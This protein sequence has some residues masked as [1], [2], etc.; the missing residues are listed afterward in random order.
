M[1]RFG[2]IAICLAGA[3]ALSAGTCAVAAVSAGNPYP[4]APIIERNV[5]G[6]NPPSAETNKTSDDAQLPKITPN[7]IMSIFGQLQVLYKVA[8]KPGTKDKDGKDVKETSYVLS[9]GQAQDEIEVV[10]IDE[11]ATLVTFNNHGTVQELPLAN[12]PKLNTPAISG[13]VGSSGSSGSI[14]GGVIP[15]RLGGPRGGISGGPTTRFGGRFGGGPGAAQNTGPGGM[16]N[17]GMNNPGT[18][19]TMGN[20][21]GSQVYTGDGP[22]QP[23]MKMTAEENAILIEAQRANYQKT[24]DPRA[25]LLPPTALTPLINNDAGQ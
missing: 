2:Q 16:N 6:L 17:P 24:G 5:F 14:G 10:H 4:Y 19:G 18:M 21:G 22:N 15:P 13:G 3:L 20:M 12:A 11:K 7:G 9:E 8:P 1:K 25:K 23:A